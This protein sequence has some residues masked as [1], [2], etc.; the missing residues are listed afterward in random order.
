MSSF[1]SDNEQPS[2]LSD[3]RFRAGRSLIMS[4]KLEEATAM[5][6]NLL[7]VVI[8]KYGDDHIETASVYYEYGNA[9]FRTA[10]ST[11]SSEDEVKIN[12]KEEKA[13]EHDAP[14]DDNDVDDIDLALE[15]M[16]NSFAIVDD[17]LAHKDQKLQSKKEN[18]CD[19]EPKGNLSL[20]SQVQIPRIL[21]G[22]G[23]LYVSK[24]NFC[25]AVDAYT[26]AIP[27]RE[28][29]VEALK[30]V[31]KESR[32]KR[33]QYLEQSR[34]LCESNVLVAETLLR[35]PR[36]KDVTVK[37]N[38]V[39]KQ[40]VLVTAVERVDFA[41]G[42]YEKARDDLQHAVYLLGDIAGS[43]VNGTKTLG[44]EKE[45]ICYLATMLMGIGTTLSDLD[46]EEEN[47]KDEK[48]KKKRA[49]LI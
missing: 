37:I 28:A 22:I 41:R 31:G 8:Q 14:Q 15:Q 47:E 17:Y 4:G 44:K 6:G 48:H 35:C 32:E 26:R 30:S 42:Y 19:S 38:G 39:D 33:L 27:Y 18:I 45:D 46:A 5:F 7:E 2:I 12:N 29:N 43:S 20:W 21:T 34:L 13:A 49:K 1:L 40:R 36:G 3:P 24:S 9:L 23:D 10:D 16:E 25:H 11:K